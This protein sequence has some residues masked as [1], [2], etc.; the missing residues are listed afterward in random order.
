MR[1]GLPLL[2]LL[3]ALPTYAATD[4]A[5]SAAAEYAQLQK[6]QFATV[7]QPLTQPVTIVRDTATWTLTSGSVK[8]MQPTA[9]GRVT[10]LVFE[11]EGAF[12]MTIPDR[13]ELAQL[14]RFSGRKSL[15]SLEQ[16]FTQLVMRVSDDSLAKLFAP[17]AGGYASSGLAEK[18]HNAWLIDQR[19][20]VD[21]RIVAATL[22]PGALQITADM[23]TA[24]F[25]WLTY[26]FDSLRQEEIRITRVQRLYPETWLSIDRAEDRREDGRPGER[27]STRAKLDSIDAKV[28][29]TRYGRTGTIGRSRQ[30]AMNGH[31]II[32]ETYTPLVSGSR[33]LTLEIA[34]SVQEIHVID[35]RDQ[36]VVTLRDHIG[37]RSANVDNRV[38]SN[39]ITLLLAEPLEQGVPRHFRFEY[40]FE[41][42]NYAPGGIW[43]PS[44]PEA[45]EPHTGRLELTVMKRHEVR[46]MGTRISEREI[47][48]AKISTWRID[49][50]AKM[51]TFSIADHSDEKTAA[52]DG[53]PQVI[54]FGPEF[55]IGGGAKAQNVATDVAA[56]LQFFQSLLDHPLG[57]ER[58]YVVSIAARHGQA[59]DGFLHLSDSTFA[60]ESLAASQLFRAHE[61]AHEWFG[62][63][64][65][66]KSYR[67]Q[68]LSEALAEYAALMFVE[69]TV[70]NG[71]KYLDEI[72]SAYEGIVE[73]NLSGGFS[74]FN[75]PWLLDFNSAHRARIG[76]IGHGYRAGTGDMST[77]YLIQTYY[78]APLV[79]HMLR[80]SLRY[81]TGSDELF[82]RI[83]RDYVHEF[84]GKEAS[85]DDFRRVI[86]KNT[87][88]DWTYFFND[89]IYGA[90]MP[91]YRWSWRAEPDANGFRVSV[92]VNRSGVADD[93][94]MPI[95]IR[96]ELDGGAATTAFINANDASQTATYVVPSKPRNVLIAPEHSLL[97]NFRRE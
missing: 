12:R 31:Y 52:A 96:I 74:K 35:E 84:A 72:L 44:S 24:D 91:S 83:L 93:F 70:K 53:I 73:G 66:W 77:A 54:A 56:S 33:A 90:E 7:A 28:D 43:Y 68:W 37:A 8:L 64:V 32:D 4:P 46:A 45:S 41:T 78:K 36:P 85:T 71:P 92:T 25:G 47:E 38:W 69:A 21:A 23:N 11:G 48:D 26:D 14:R 88:S 65:G 13:V 16:K 17:P 39:T 5:S 67:D 15:Q 89:W 50:P 63:E 29:L 97:G 30:R 10:G 18:R 61:V 79:L 86:E 3:L 62:L 19:S 49:K 27:R 51:I 9:S 75:R 87:G 2:L 1:P 20:D 94:V 6:W 42:S 34:S 58:F 82:V 81:K 80:M 59:F 22:N 76:P 57:G 60:T 40:D 95:P 55:G